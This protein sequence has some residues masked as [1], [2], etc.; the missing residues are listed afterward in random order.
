MSETSGSYDEPKIDAAVC[1]KH[2]KHSGLTRRNFL[3]T[4]GVV[5]GSI[6]AAA[7]FGTQ[8]A[9]AVQFEDG[10]SLDEGETITTTVC[11][12]NCS[13]ACLFNVHKRNGNV[14]KLSPK[15]YETELYSGCCLRGMSIQ[16]RTYSDKRVKYP[17]RRVEGT[18]RGAGEWE[19]ISWDEAFEEVGTK[20]KEIQEK[21]GKQALVVS[22]LSGNACSLNGSGSFLTLFANA[23]QATLQGYS[24]D[25]AFEYAAFR[26]VG[27]F[28]TNETADAV[29]AK[30]IL[31]WGYN[32]VWAS[33][34]TWRC[35]L[36]ARDAGAK[37]VVV[38]PVYSASAAQADK[39]IPVKPGTDALIALALL[40]KVLSEKTYDE[41]FCK[42]RTTAPCL[43]RR[44]TKTLLKQSDF[45]EELRALVQDSDSSTTEYAQ[46]IA[47]R[48]AAGESGRIDDFYV[49]DTEN[50][51]AALY[52]ECTNPALFGSFEVNGIMVDTVFT[53]LSE[54][55]SEFSYERAQEESGIS[56]D[57]LDYLYQCYTEEGPLWLAGMYGIDHYWN[58]HLWSYAAAELSGITGN[59]G[60]HGATYG[61]LWNSGTQVNVNGD[62]SSVP[63]KGAS[64]DLVP[65]AMR[66]VII[67]GKYQG[68]DFPIKAMLITNA[69]TLSNEPDQNSYLNE[70]LPNL[71]FVVTMDIE[72]TDSA[73][74]ADIVLPVSFWLEQE[75]IRLNNGNPYLAISEKAIDSLY[76]SKPDFEIFT[77]LARVMGLEKDVPERTAEEWIND[78]MD[79]N[80]FKTRNITY[81]RL[82][83]EKAI[84]LVGSAEEPFVQAEKSFPTDSG[85]VEL[86]CENPQ[87]R[88][89]FG[90]DWSSYVE[91]E[92]MPYWES[93]LEV[94]DKELAQKY[95]LQFLQ[96]HTRWMTHTQ[97]FG[98]ESLNELM[99]EPLVYI[100]EN[101]AAARNIK[102]GDVVRVYNDR[103]F[104]KVKCSIHN[105]IQDGIAWMSKGWQ[106]SQ[107]IEG[108][109]Q[110][111][112]HTKVNPMSVNFNY[113][114]IR[115]QVE[116][117]A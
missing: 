28:C 88:Y 2:A 10:T 55:V 114:D 64:S 68:K 24:T 74:Y 100:N 29:N 52:S 25:Q 44:D 89:D 99:P 72:F 65:N 63:G 41:Q 58:G 107:F 96:V 48:A 22:R 95:P 32:P 33:P 70:V 15:A 16:E 61:S 20:F 82:K 23:T 84:R 19:R 40:N 31:I 35:F 108:C 36:A 34:Q 91:L 7:T 75:D 87:P 60:K 37:I 94:A 101:E 18:E 12:S 17:L 57:D 110:E 92:R 27:S 71:E 38:D 51:K 8:L 112:S 42:T 69:N 49:W 56:A 73:R 59:V 13:Q 62:W 67:T 113:Y 106:R 43:V 90:Q 102:E 21:Y 5:A 105:G 116:K 39:Y 80:D 30:T 47:A 104:V 6:A 1:Q 78:I 76:E 9:T 97:W 54:R 14:V 117:E 83:K 45:D 66:D 11:R 111:L 81:D 109:Y 4:T 3:K 98:N 115:V 46:L 86:Y 85:L 77:G 79:C 93:S 53:L 26:V 103:G 50:Q